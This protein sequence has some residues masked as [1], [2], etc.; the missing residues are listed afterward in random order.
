MSLKLSVVLFFWSRIT[1]KAEYR[2]CEQ[3]LLLHV[4]FL[5][6][7]QRLK[8][9]PPFAAIHPRSLKAEHILPFCSM[10]AL[11]RKGEPKHISERTDNRNLLSGV[12]EPTKIMDNRICKKSNNAWTGLS[13][14]RWIT[15][16][17]LAPLGYPAEPESQS[18]VW[19]VLL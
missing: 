11:F 15:P 12:S 1:W 7:Q 17:C 16:G 19:S 13:E 3:L 8:R 2:S 14:S 18:L 9:S 6:C 5:C 10:M 4:A